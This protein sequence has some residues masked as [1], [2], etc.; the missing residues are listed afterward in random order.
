[1][2][3]QLNK[4]FTDVMTNTCR[5]VWLRYR[6]QIATSLLVF[7]LS[8]ATFVSAAPV[9]GNEVNWVY[10]N[11][12]TTGAGGFPLTF[13]TQALDFLTSG[14]LEDG[15]GTASAF[16]SLSGG[17]LKGSVSGV[18]GNCCQAG[19][20]SLR[21]GLGAQIDLFGPGDVGGVVAV[22]MH[23]TGDLGLTDGAA[24]QI[25]AQSG[26]G[27]D[28]PGVG[29]AS[30]GPNLRGEFLLTTDS[31]DSLTC[32]NCTFDP[33][34]YFPISV[35]AFLP[36][37]PGDDAVHYSAQLHLKAAGNA[38]HSSAFVDASHTALFSI[39]V[40]DGFTFSSALAVTAVPEPQIY[41]LLLAGLGFVGYAA[42][43]RTRC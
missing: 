33:N 3:R 32:R 12:D 15:T 4:H 23:I 43:R 38:I 2:L 6:A 5:A 29:F 40:P 14:S 21:I 9:I 42:R 24:I 8:T 41:G 16:A 28:T 20:A 36:F 35:T 13:D 25:Q 31:L 39:V 34:H 37:N 27:L 19:Q 18:T 22:T 17:F 1:M 10:G 11:S 26:P 30:T 7:V